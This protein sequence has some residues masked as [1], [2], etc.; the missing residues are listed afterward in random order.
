MIINICTVVMVTVFCYCVLV[1]TAK[2]IEVL[3]FLKGGKTGLT[4]K[5]PRRNRPSNMRRAKW[6]SNRSQ[7]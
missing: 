4:R 3:E 7:R 1:I 5:L 6:I 2:T